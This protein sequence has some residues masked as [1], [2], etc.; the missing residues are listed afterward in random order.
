MLSSAVIGPAAANLGS[1]SRMLTLRYDPLAK[2]VRAPLSA[3]DFVPQKTA[4]IEGRIVEIIKEGLESR[5]GEL[6]F[7]RASLS[8]S[9]GVD[10]GMTMAMLSRFLPDVKLD[11]IS[12]GFGDKDDET[13]RAK[14]IARAYNCN[15]H[16]ML[17]DD[18]LT[19]LPKLIGIVKE[20]RWNLYHYYPVEAGKKTSSVFYS[21][22]GGDELFGG[23]T[24]RYS[25]FLSLMTGG[26]G[27]HDRA[28]AYLSCHERDWVPDQD[29]MFGRAVKF[30]WDAISKPLRVN[31]DN[32]LSPI[33][34]VFLA[35]FNGK[36][37]HDW[38]PTNKAFEKH[39]GVKIE[40]IF[41]TDEMIRL[42]THIPWQL[43]YDPKTTEGKMPLRAILSRQKGFES[44]EP[45]KKGFS[46]NL[47]SMWDRGAREIVKRYVNQDSEVVRQEIISVDWIKKT[48]GNL[49]KEP[50]QRYI[51]KM[52]S[53]L[54]LEVWYRLFVSRTMKPAERL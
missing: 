39:L 24:F 40:S 12:V 29:L 34:Q 9:A 26:E 44:I 45:V 30:S 18:V 14:E 5:H 22:D 23:Y 52:L 33:D 50:N 25:K 28:K 41:L 15:F 35:D 4:G 20:P 27:W 19:G 31:F 49:E 21:G 54:A 51:S 48:T 36:L 7:K 16:E 11:C 8:L 32:N 10:S 46:A 38:L 53:I 17:L 42:A 3:E 37:L 47:A 2:P 13:E 1:I 6:G 43:K